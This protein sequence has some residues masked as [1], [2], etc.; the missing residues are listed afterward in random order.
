MIKPEKK[1]K[2]TRYGQRWTKY[3][4]LKQMYDDVETEM[5]E[6]GVAIQLDHP[7]WMDEQGNTVPESDSKGFKVKVKLTIPDMCIV[8]DEVG[9]NLSMVKDG[10]VGGEKF[11]VGKGKEAKLKATKCDKKFTCLGLTLLSGEP[12][13]CV[14]LVD[15]TK[16]D[17]LIRT[18]VDCSTPENTTTNESSENEVQ[19]EFDYLINNLGKGKQYPGGSSCVYEGK[20]IPCMV[21]FTS[22]GTMSGQILTKIFRTLD[23]LKIFQESRNKVIRPLVLVDGYGSRFDVEFLQYIN[24]EN[25]R[26]SVCIG[27]PYGTSLWQVGDSVQQNGVFKVR[28]TMIKQ[29]ILECRF[30]KM[31]GIELIPFDIIPIVNF[32]WM[33]SFQNK[34]KQQE[35]NFE[36]GWNPLNRMLLLHPEL[37]ADM[38]EKDVEWEVDSDLYNNHNNIFNKKGQ[39]NQL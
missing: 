8:I 16:E 1:R 17:L 39:N 25:H 12:L 37:R 14:I 23:E 22:G 13:L 24:N 15:S 20:Q 9:S 10:H 2:A 4:N 36:R 5:V 19:D 28:I 11:V 3:R 35:G 27:V 31:M 7:I 33:G 26:W 32:A 21:E 18:G 29:K 38:T 30:E 6:A 34:K